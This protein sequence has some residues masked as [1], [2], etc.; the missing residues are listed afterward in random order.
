MPLSLSN[1]PG[2]ACVSSCWKQWPLAQSQ[3]HREPLSPAVKDEK[4]VAMQGRGKGQCQGNQCER[5]KWGE[6]V[7]T[8]SVPEP[9][10]A[11][12]TSC[13]GLT[14]SGQKEASQCQGDLW[15][16]GSG[17]WPSTKTK[18][19]HCHQLQNSRKGDGMQGA[20]DGHRQCSPART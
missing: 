12:V 18:S 6:A 13:R 4:G 14:G 2:C 7:T 5:R 10:G 16:G 8:G 1:D 19:N 15:E 17:H 20:K 3:N 11:I 9:Q